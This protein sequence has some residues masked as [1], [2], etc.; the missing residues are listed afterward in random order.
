MKAK[1]LRVGSVVFESTE[2]G[3]VAMPQGWTFDLEGKAIL[4]LEI[5][6]GVRLWGGWTIQDLLEIS[7]RPAEFVELDI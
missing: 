7:K 6:D 3:D 1:I 4:P 5:R 2:A